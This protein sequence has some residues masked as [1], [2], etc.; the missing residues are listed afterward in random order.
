MSVAAAYLKLSISLPS[1]APAGT[2]TP[3]I[4]AYTCTAI[5]DASKKLAAPLVA[6]TGYTCSMDVLLTSYDVTGAVPEFKVTASWVHTSASGTTLY[7]EAL[8]IPTT[9]V[10]H[11]APV[12]TGSTLSVAVPV[13]NA[14]DGLDA[15]K[16]V[17][18]RYS[19]QHP[20]V[21]RY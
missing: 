14:D 9:T 20:A 12:Y 19:V 8:L 17:A 10:S 1:S 2:V 21:A 18:G 13:I 16:H 6:N 5:I 4:A 11:P 15:A 3:T 7:D